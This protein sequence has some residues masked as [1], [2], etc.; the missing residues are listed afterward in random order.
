MSHI[1]SLMDSWS[2]RSLGGELHPDDVLAVLLLLALYHSLLSLLQFYLTA[3]ELIFL[4][5]KHFCEWVELIFVMAFGLLVRLG[6]PEFLRWL[7][8]RKG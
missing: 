5:R 6:V 3:F 7:R 8:M 4:F 1:C 2:R